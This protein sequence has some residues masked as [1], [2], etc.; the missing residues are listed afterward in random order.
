MRRNISMVERFEDGYVAEPNTGCWLWFKAW[1]NHGY[2]K[3]CGFGK[4]RSMAAHRFAYE[5]ANGPIPPGMVIDHL[6][7]TPACVNP[8][9]LEAVTQHEN[10]LRGIKG[11]GLRHGVCLRG[12]A[13][14]PRHGGRHTYCRECN[15]EWHR[16]NR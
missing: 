11:K 4:G 13:V 2:G 1:N 8:A 3:I 15:T 10:T 5:L 9:H 6:C 16:Q 7:R 14:R 12:H